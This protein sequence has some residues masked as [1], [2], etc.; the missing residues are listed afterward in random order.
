MLRRPLRLGRQNGVAEPGSQ[1]ASRA[2]YVGAGKVDKK[3]VCSLCTVVRTI[4]TWHTHVHTFT[5]AFDSQWIH[6][7]VRMTIDSRHHGAYMP[8]HTFP[9][10]LAHN[11]LTD[12][13][14]H[15]GR[16]LWWMKM[17][18]MWVPRDECDGVRVQGGASTSGRG[19]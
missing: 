14:L 17:Q 7:I 19:Q 16:G 3:G 4:H 18:G 6:N 10:P 5:A 8:R 1:A 9:A 13:A 11:T 12:C 2:G 15:A